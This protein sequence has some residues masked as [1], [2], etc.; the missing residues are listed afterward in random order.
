M[1]KILSI[2]LNILKD[3]VFN[4]FWKTLP[5]IIIVSISLILNAILWYIFE[6]KIKQNPLPFIFSSGLIFL[7][8]ILGNFLWEREKM[9]SYFLISVGFF[10]QVLMLILIRYLTVVF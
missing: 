7:N 3:F 1:K 5:V 6:V 2:L 4:S 8:L 10:T 9:A